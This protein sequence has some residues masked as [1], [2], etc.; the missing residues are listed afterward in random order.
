MA[1]ID[2]P[3]LTSLG[4]ET[5]RLIAGRPLINV[6]RMWAHSEPLLPL[7]AGLGAT[8]FASLRLSPRHRE[9][10]VLAVAQALDAPYIADQHASIS[11]ACGVT[12]AEREALGLGAH[13][14]LGGAYFTTAEV[15]LVQFAIAS[16][17]AAVV[18][19]YYFA[20]MRRTFSA[21]EI[22]E[23][24]SVV[25]YYFT[26]A[27]MTTVLEIESDAAGDTSVIDAGI[28]MAGDQ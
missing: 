21:Q 2:Y 4:P 24:L 19:D 1:R 7:I 6:L 18:P 5:T 17:G 14:Q 15:V 13:W 27:R 23:T 25:G 28:A 11:D 8:Q 12:A 16:L 26:I 10:V 9:L 22:V 20:A 3:D